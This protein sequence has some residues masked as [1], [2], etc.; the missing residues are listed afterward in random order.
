MFRYSLPLL[1]GTVS[2]LGWSEPAEA[3]QFFGSSGTRVNVDQGLPERPGGFTF[4]R[5][6]YRSYRSDPS[7][8]GWRTDFPEAD[9]NLVTRLPQLTPTTISQWS[10]GE[11]GFAVVRPTDPDLYRCPFLMATDVGEIG[12]SP[13]EVEAMRNYLLKGGFFWADDFWGTAAWSYFEAEIRRILP[14]YEIIELP[15]DHP[16]LEIVYTVPRIPQIPSINFWS[17]SGGE[18]SELGFDSRDPSMRAV[19]DGTGRILVLA[20]HNTDISDGWER[21]AYDP[22]FFQLFSPD[23]Y[24]IGINVAVW[25]MTH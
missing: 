16:L 17:R 18:T 23:A 12:F 24:A 22:R 14:E 4:C 5:L 6:A 11:L 15:M 13:E 1:L 25:V 20:T 8:N 10:H 9:R 7:G 21:E 2:L 3:R 19:I